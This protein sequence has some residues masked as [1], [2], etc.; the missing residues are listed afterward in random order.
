MVVGKFLSIPGG[1]GRLG[2]AMAR[3]PPERPRPLRCAAVALAAA[4]GR[5]GAGAAAA[6]EAPTVRLSS[7]EALPLVGL[8]VG[9]LAHDLIEEAVVA[10]VDRHG[11]RLIDTAAASKNEHIVAA[12]L[13][14]ADRGSEVTVLTKVWHTHLGFERTL[15]SVG[16]SLER[17]GLGGDGA[18]RPA[19]LLHWPR[20][21]SDVSWMRCEEEEAELPQEVR[22]LGPAPH[23][24]ADAWQGS[25]RALEQLYREGLISSIGV[26]NFD[27][28]QM[29]AL[30]G[31]AEI[32]PHI[33]QGSLWHLLFDPALMEV[34]ERHG[35]VF[36][37]T[38]VPAGAVASAACPACS[39]GC[40]SEYD[41]S[42]NSRRRSSWTTKMTTSGAS[43]ARRRRQ[44]DLL[45]PAR[46]VQIGMMRT[47]IPKTSATSTTQPGLRPPDN[48]ARIK[49]TA[50]TTTASAASPAQLNQ[51]P[52]S[53]EQQIQLRPPHQR[54][55]P[56]G[57]RAASDSATRTM[58]G[59]TTSTPQPD[60][61]NSYDN[62]I[63]F[64]LKVGRSSRSEARYGLRALRPR[65]C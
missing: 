21:R 10:A 60:V 25:W 45:T 46:D 28:R 5:A 55:R 38:T 23:L 12:A 33:L 35:V 62:V 14:R 57:S 6:E 32:K 42:V 11:V 41:I 2:I 61:T 24:D 54:R 22:R 39:G 43:P 3:R 49:M 1:F 64:N 13:R 48:E 15:F 29:E 63:G 59:T 7:G 37:A 20:C 53:S 58:T 40:K 44:H 16:E 36:Q 9:N 4:A 56:L 18:R 31:M 50:R 52:P 27:P 26:S 17:L 30:A 65:L 47:I 19:V 51:R 8:G 34:L